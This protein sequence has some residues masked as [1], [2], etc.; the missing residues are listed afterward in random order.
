[1]VKALALPEIHKHYEDNGL[2]PVGNTPE[3]FAEFLRKDIALQ[4]EIAKRIGL[5]PQ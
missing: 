4:A 5:Q 1:M 2:V 3:E